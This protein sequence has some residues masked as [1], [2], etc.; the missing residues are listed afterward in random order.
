MQALFCHVRL[1][2]G[3][4]IWAGH[5]PSVCDNSDPLSGCFAAEIAGRASYVGSPS[6]KADLPGMFSWRD[7]CG[8]V[9]NVDWTLR[10]RIVYK[11]AM[12]LRDLRLDTPIFIGG[13]SSSGNSLLARMFSRHPEVYCGQEMSLFNKRQI[14]G[15]FSTV[16][17]SLPGWLRRGLPTDGY[18]LYPRI[19]PHIEDG[20]LTPEALLR[21][22]SKANSL[23]E[24]ADNVQTHVLHGSGK[25]LLAEK[26]PSD[27][28]C[29]RQLARL[30]PNCT[31]IHSVRDGRD[32]ACSLMKRGMDIF[33]ATSIWM[34]NA[35]C[36][37]ACRD[38]PNYMEVR[39]EEMVQD[40]TAMLERICQK[41]SI[42]FDPYMLRPSES[43]RTSKFAAAGAWKSNTRDPI[44]QKSV[45]RYK[46]DMSAADYAAFCNVQLT[47]AGMRQVGGPQTTAFELLRMLGYSAELPEQPVSWLRAKFLDA[48]D[49]FRQGRRLVR[50][51][52]RPRPALTQMALLSTSPALG[53][54]HRDL[55]RSA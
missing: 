32:V 24:F 40:P 28:Y 12:T 13:A 36:G 39:Y 16:K 49:R 17:R 14:Y 50:K 11:A 5:T 54:M 23:R 1:S 4:T 9:E 26:T 55:A 29:F 33:E 19:I 27:V 43:E 44:N 47:A 46:T 34:Y 37:I 18:S 51:G 52:Y 15:D 7:R 10:L 45:G 53:A 8:S 6:F 35:A 42:S 48:N 30:Y 41:A 20:L 22:M 25:R 31:L 3:S 38:L 2:C 21:A